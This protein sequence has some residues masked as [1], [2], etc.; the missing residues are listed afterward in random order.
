M[1]TVIDENNLKVVRLQIVD[2]ITGEPLDYVNVRTNAQSINF[3]DGQF[4]EDAF[5]T[6][7]TRVNT[8]Q[9][10]ETKTR[11]D[12]DDHLLHG[13]HVIVDKIDNAIIGTTW[14][15][16]TGI[17]T[18]YRYDGTSYE[19]DTVM[20]KIFLDV[21]FDE[22]T[23]EIIF[24][25]DNGNKT[26]VNVKKLVDIYSGI[27]TDYVKTTVSN[28]NKIKVE[29]KEKGILY[30]NLADEITE[31][32]RDSKRFI[33]AYEDKIKG[34]EENA[35]NYTLPTADDKTL[36]GVKI[37]T[38]I[39]INDGVITAANV[40]YGESK[41]TATPVNLFLQVDSIGGP[42]TDPVPEMEDATSYITGEGNLIDFISTTADYNYTDTTTGNVETGLTADQI[43]AKFFPGLELVNR[44][45]IEWYNDGT[46]NYGV[47]ASGVGFVYQKDK[48][49]FVKYIE[50][51]EYVK[52]INERVLVDGIY[53]EPDPE[54][55]TGGDDN[56]TEE[57]GDNQS[58]TN[59][60][61]EGSESEK[62]PS[63]SGSD[64]SDTNK[65]TEEDKDTSGEI[66]N[67]T[68]PSGKEPSSSDDKTPET[69]ESG[70]TGT[71]G[72]GK[73][74]DGNSDN[75]ETSG[76]EG[77]GDDSV[78]GETPSADE[79]TGTEKS[80]GDTNK[81]ETDNSDTT[82]NN[83]E[84]TDNTPATNTDSSEDG[85]DPS[86]SNT[87]DTQSN[88]DD[89]SQDTNPDENTD[90]SLSENKDDESNNT[91]EP[92]SELEGETEEP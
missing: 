46:Y 87:G 24:T 79:N 90:N 2:E 65:D 6:L 77:T 72:E 23:C 67:N 21:E 34:I 44:M 28:T 13:G 68:D 78:T 49:V 29:I 71:N 66:S 58:E 10:A 1:A 53:V 15:R 39:G 19:W 73:D 69:S 57:N 47:T 14:D 30:E 84:N 4:L 7:V 33:D 64:S 74:T 88:V 16:E 60:S 62:T 76:T 85:D 59:G 75:G 91:T 89:S 42:S 45:N 55:S 81:E 86:K 61:E 3:S 50:T 22:D 25:M 41:D 26:R 12:L 43:K 9:V 32:L 56:K 38:N 92:S 31:Y 48:W 18:F 36:G 27:E 5:K 54:P 82:N 35:N 51:Q 8:L 52:L 70:D 40:L 17:L 11:S 37:G 83:P 63:E 80:D 20:E